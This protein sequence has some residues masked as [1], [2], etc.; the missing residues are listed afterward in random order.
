MTDHADH[1]DHDHEHADAQPPLNRE[2]RRAQKFH[3]GAGS[4]R[5]DNLH[6]QRENASGFLTEPPSASGDDVPRSVVEP[7]EASVHGGPGTGGATEDA[8]RVMHHEGEHLG[9][10]SKS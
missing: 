7:D 9:N 4:R 10:P 8:G 1:S 2:Q 3:K 6:T 5:Q